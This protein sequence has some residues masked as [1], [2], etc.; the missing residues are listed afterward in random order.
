M[1]TM[2]TMMIWEVLAFF[3]VGFSGVLAVSIEY[4]T[5]RQ[6]AGITQKGQP[7]ARITL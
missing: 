2:I 3:A 4:E 7:Q 6:S 5:Q 1:M